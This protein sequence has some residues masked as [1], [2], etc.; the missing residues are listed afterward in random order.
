MLGLK[1]IEKCYRRSYAV[2]NK[3][4]KILNM[5]QL[6]DEPNENQPVDAEYREDVSYNDF[7]YEVM[8]MNKMFAMMSLN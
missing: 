6:N 7:L 5:P 2:E 1:K 8:D 4:R 3:I